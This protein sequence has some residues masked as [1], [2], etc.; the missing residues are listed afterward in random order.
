MSKILS[1]GQQLLQKNIFGQRNSSVP[2][3]HTRI[4]MSIRAD[5]Q[6]PSISAIDQIERDRLRGWRAIR[7]K[8][9]V[10]P[11]T[12][13]HLAGCRCDFVRDGRAVPPTYSVPYRLLCL[14]GAASWWNFQLLLACYI[15]NVHNQSSWATSRKGGIAWHSSRF[16]P[17][18]WCRL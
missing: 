12:A 11:N 1:L 2:G 6:Y 7:P 10:W 14:T 16:M 18:L 17:S 4:E 9:S 8:A 5:R 3:C 13:A 15:V